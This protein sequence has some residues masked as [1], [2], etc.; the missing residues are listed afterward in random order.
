MNLSQQ[1]AAGFPDDRLQLFQEI[2]RSAD[3]RKVNAV[4]VGGVVRDL[5]LGQ[6]VKDADIMLEHPAKPF[7][8]ELA[9]RL[10]AKLV[11]HERFF[12]FTLH[13]PDGQKIDIVTAREE[14]YAS[15]GKLPDVVPSTFEKDLKR[16]DF[17]INA[18]ACRLNQ[19][20]F[21][22]TLDLFR[23]EED[24]KSGLVRALHADSFG[25][26][27]TRIYRAARF[28]GR[29]GFKIE[30]KTESWILA[31]IASE[32][33]LLLSP[34]RRRHEFELILKERNPL[35]ALHLLQKWDAVRF[36]HQDW[37]RVDLDSLNFGGEAVWPDR[38][39]EW[40][41]RW[42]KD[43]TFKMMTDLSFEKTIKHKV[44]SKLVQSPSKS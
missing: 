39:V 7:V 17:T 22:Q 10:N 6:P 40:F 12:T 11:A 32:F 41:Q 29:F 15:P 27:P 18:M 8:E 3:E 28:A 43:R 14:T 44:L 25:D 4:F 24:L 31:S 42:G 30:N 33:P 36:I 5:L 35:P 26:D 16:R 9:R 13:L 2:G 1:I 38:L 34:V 21:G 37:K 23:G 20:K 19:A